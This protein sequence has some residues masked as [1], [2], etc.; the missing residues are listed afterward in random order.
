MTGPIV[1]TQINQAY[2]AWRPDGGLRLVVSSYL[3]PHQNEKWHHRLQNHVRIYPVQGTPVPS[4]GFTYLVFDDGSAAWIR[5]ATAGTTEGRNNSRALIGRDD[6]LDFQ[7]AVGLSLRPGWSDEAPPSGQSSPQPGDKVRAAAGSTETLLPSVRD[8]QDDVAAVLAGLLAN[9]AAAL[10]VIGGRE[11]ERLA[12]VWALHRIA[13]R[14]LP[15]R[16]RDRRDWSFSTYEDRHDTGAG[17]LPGIVF[18]PARQPGAGAINRIIVDLAQPRV[19]PDDLTLAHRVVH[20][21]IH[22]LPPDDTIVD[23]PAGHPQPRP[24]TTAGTVPRQADPAAPAPAERSPIADLLEAPDVAAFVRELGR[25][26]EMVTQQRLVLYPRVDPPVV[27]RLTEFVEV[28]A[29][30]ELLGRLLWVLYGP[31]LEVGQ[32]NTK[33]EK[34]AAKVI[35][36]GRSDQLARMLGAAAP[37]RS[38]IRD[39]AFDRWADAGRP[40]AGKAGQ[41]SEQLRTARRSRWFPWVTAG[42]AVLAAAVVFLLGFLLG[43]P[44]NPAAAGTPTASPTAVLKP[45]TAVVKPPTEA[46]QAPPPTA[47]D[48]PPAGQDQGPQPSVQVR[49]DQG[50]TAWVFLRTGQDQFIPLAGCQQVPASNDW[51]CAKQ[52]NQDGEQVAMALP[53]GTDL[54]S[55]VNQQVQRGAGW[56]KPQRIS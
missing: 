15:Q 28:S 18:L 26:E 56:G 21:L 10:S 25:L 32:G 17:E 43:R 19:D 8:Y 22:N 36:D 27:D 1:D 53:A 37:P 33:A 14:Y 44:G 20:Y 35:K 51:T 52:A 31:R 11:P 3:D 42:A 5:R 50:G 30:T 34:H 2:F 54:N 49:A 7:A 46:T 16:F 47:P 13:E 24:S 48:N 29:R 40:P 4:A 41:L 23:V 6:L 9:P 39:V 12:I 38:P 45:T 55:Q